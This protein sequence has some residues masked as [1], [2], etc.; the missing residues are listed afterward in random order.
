[1][2]LCLYAYFYRLVVKSKRQERQEVDDKV[3]EVFTST[4]QHTM[5][6]GS[7]CEW[8]KQSTQTQVGS[9]HSIFGVLF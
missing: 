1:L 9:N 4:N 8:Q 7:D 3:F 5:D 6:G 2:L